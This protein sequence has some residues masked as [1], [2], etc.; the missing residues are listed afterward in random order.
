MEDTTTRMGRP[1]LGRENTV[2]TK[3]PD[4]EMKKLREIAAVLGVKPGRFASDHF[5]DFIRSINLDDLRAQY[6]QEA[7]IQ[8]AS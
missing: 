8:K 4:A 6:G 1:P 7:L 3:L 2:A 5:I